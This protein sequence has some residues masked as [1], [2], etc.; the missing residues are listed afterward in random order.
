MRELIIVS[1][2][3][4]PILSMQAQTHLVVTSSVQTV[5]VSFPSGKSRSY[6]Y[7]VSATSSVTE[8]ISNLRMSAENNTFK[9]T[10]S[11]AP[12]KVLVKK[13]MVLGKNEAVKITPLSLSSTNSALRAK[14]AT[15]TF[16]RVGVS[17]AIAIP[18]FNG[19]NRIAPTQLETGKSG[20]IKK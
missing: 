18:T 7:S 3:L 16:Q 5:G 12:L 4:L 13:K 9:V 1:A 15:Q 8:K 17:K 6:G 10:A 11:N 20:F 2:L 14:F 19:T